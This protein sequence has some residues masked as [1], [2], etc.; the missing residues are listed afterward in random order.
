MW[1]KKEIDCL[2]KYFPIGRVDSII[3]E[4]GRSRSAI[5]IKANRLNIFILPRLNIWYKKTPLQIRIYLAGHFDGE[6]CARFA[7]RTGVK[8][9]LRVSPSIAVNICNLKTLNLYKKYFNGKIR[10]SKTGFNKQMYLW[11]C[12]KFED[13]YNFILSVIPYSIEKREQLKLLKLFIDKRIKLGKSKSLPKSFI[14]LGNILSDKCTS[15]KKM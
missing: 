6:G 15:L 4:T 12:R 2:I 11:S 3:K 14:S 13:V 10:I 8:S 5:K 9:N 7:K 1:D